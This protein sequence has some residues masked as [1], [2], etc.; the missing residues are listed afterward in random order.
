MDSR[1]HRFGFLFE[2]PA[3]ST[4]EAQS[5]HSLFRHRAK[6][7]RQRVHIAVQLSESMLI[8]HLVDWLHKD[9]RSAN[10]LFFTREPD[11]QKGRGLGQAFISG[12]E[13]ARR[14]LFDSTTTGS[15]SLKWAFYTHP[16]YLGLKKEGYNRSY[17][18]YSLGIILFE[19]P[20]WKQ[21]LAC[22]QEADERQTPNESDQQQVG[23]AELEDEHEARNHAYGPNGHSRPAKDSL[24]DI[25]SIRKRILEGP[26]QILE[27]V[28]NVMGL[29]YRKAV[30]AC[31]ESMTAIGLSEDQNQKDPVA[32][33]L[34][35]QEVIRVVIDV[36]GS[37][38]V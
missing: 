16:D 26:Q 10:V 37:I 32:A 15:I 20:Y 31:I 24:S 19:L 8:F 17:D 28:E 2:P 13:F 14:S 27:H 30:T 12:F 1:K 29:K 9:M 21:I 4:A 7:P 11:S 3:K 35:Q 6:R 25:R 23:D 33:T 36:Y 18:I 38:E 22:E 34:M 5:L